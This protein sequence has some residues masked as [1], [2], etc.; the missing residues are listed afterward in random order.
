GGVAAFHADFGA[1]DLRQLVAAGE[2]QLVEALV[3]RDDERMLGAE[4]R[5]GFGV[6]RNVS[7]AGDADELTAH[8]RRVGQRTH[9]VEDRPATE[10]FADRHDAAHRWMVLA[11]EE[12]A[13]AEVGKRLLGGVHRPVEVEAEGFE[14]VSRAGLRA[15]GAVAVL[16][17]RHA[18]GGNDQRN[19][20][21]DIE[22]VV[23]V[24]AG[25]ADVDR[26]GGRF[27]GDQPGAHR[28]C[29]AGDF[30]SGLAAVGQFGEE[31]GDV[32]VRQGPV[33]HRAEGGFGF[34]FLERMIDR[35]KPGHASALAGM[36][37]IFMKLASRSCPC[38]VA[39]LSGWNCTPWIG[40][41]RW[42]KPMTLVPSRPGVSL[43][44]LTMSVSGMSSTTSE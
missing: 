37:Q 5:Q 15:G 20:G 6:D 42:R 38:S 31:T 23:A 43:V 24:P 19:G 10:R 17:D 21:R 22:R 25:A 16:G 34:A 28:A 11:G 44:A 18:A 13:D 35:G 32:L 26:V 2:A 36:S 33:E 9:Q 4:A 12:E 39:M 1:L 3:A 30:G 40:S 27:D 8:V 29:G 7:R 41:S 14:R